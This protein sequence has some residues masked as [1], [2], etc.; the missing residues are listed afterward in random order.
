M[1]TRKVF[2]LLSA[3]GLF[4]FAAGWAA[5]TKPPSKTAPAKASAKSTSTEKPKQHQATGTVVSFTDTS[6]AIS[7]NTGRNKSNWTFVR[8]AK[9]SVQGTLAKNAKVTVYYHEDGD[10][11]IAHRVKVLEASKSATGKSTTSKPGSKPAKST[12]PN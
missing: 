2:S 6:L 11:R 8:N 5:Q 9:T 7:K 3:L 4:A 10:K 1:M 12:T